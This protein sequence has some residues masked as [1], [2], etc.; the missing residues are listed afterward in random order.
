MKK[1]LSFI[2]LTFGLVLLTSCSLFGEK[3]EEV[4]MTVEQMQALVDEVDFSVIADDVFVLK[5]DIDIKTN[6][7][8]KTVLEEDLELGF[9]VLGSLG[10]YADLK[11]FE[12][13]YIYANVDLSYELTGDVDK[14]FATQLYDPVYDGEELP[15]E[16]PEEFDITRYT[17]GSFVGK[18]YVIKGTLYLNAKVTYP[19]TSIE[20]KQYEEV[21]TEE[22][23]D[24]M[25]QM[26][27]NAFNSEE[28]KP[29]DVSSIPEDFGLNVY[30]IGDSYEFEIRT[31]AEIEELINDLMNFSL[32]YEELN[33]NIIKNTAFDNYMTI[34]FSDKLEKIGLHS[35]TD[36]HFKVSNTE[37]SGESIEVKLFTKV[38]FTLDFKGKMPRN[39]P[40]ETDLNDY[41]EGI[42]LN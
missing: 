37:E 42:N 36:V 25:K 21:F 11:T 17:S 30:K 20:I 2:L 12:D 18:I 29:F 15:L 8:I 4:E 3:R 34:K 35:K 24:L 6:F 13:S 31:P 22:G 16:I 27:E 32:E 23:F 7:I 5:T 33:I 19:G 10:I 40:K 41:I 1:L 26:I 38:N 28:E 9:E 14:L 39:L